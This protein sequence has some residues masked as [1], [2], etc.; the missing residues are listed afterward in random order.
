MQEPLRRIIC[1]KKE[2]IR[3]DQAQKNQFLPQIFEAGFHIVLIRGD[4][5]KIPLWRGW[6]T[7]KPALETILNHAGPIAIVPGSSK[8]FPLMVVDI[9]EGT[10]D[11]IRERP[12]CQYDTRR[13]NHLYFYTESPTGKH[14][15]DY[16]ECKGQVIGTSGYV[17]LHDNGKALCEAI[18]RG[19]LK[20]HPLPTGLRQ[21]DKEKIPDRSNLQATPSNT[22]KTLREIP[23]HQLEQ[24]TVGYRNNA[25]F[26]VVRL[27]AYQLE[28]PETIEKLKALIWFYAHNQNARFPDPLSSDEVKFII[29]SIAQ[30]KWKMS[31]NKYDHSSE[32]QSR[33]G[34]KSSRLRQ[35]RNA[36]RDKQIMK[37]LQSRV[38][39]KELA[40]IYKLSTRQ[41]RRIKAARTQKKHKKSPVHLN[42]P[43]ITNYKSV[44]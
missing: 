23:N 5:S 19:N 26:D 42:S 15:F 37:D 40:R 10:P 38:S 13:G 1:N 14:N 34:I 28:T 31:G 36:R 2:N 41:I 6:N 33:R 20:Q 29:E 24:C 18:A 30:F 27:N 12:W 7:K 3:F 22:S 16:K 44:I 9:D 11:K 25:L 35:A 39:V 21:R 43:K 17:L 4:N 8:K 32:A